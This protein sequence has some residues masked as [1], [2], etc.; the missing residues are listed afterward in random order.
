M[1]WR[2]QR[3]GVELCHL[4]EEAEDVVVAH[5]QRL[6]AGQL[7][8]LRLECRHHLAAVVTQL[9][10]V[11][12]LLAVAG[13]DEAPVTLQMRKLVDKGARKLIGKHALYGSE[14][15]DDAF[16]LLRQA[17]HAR[18]RLQQGRTR[19]RHDQPV[20]HSAEIARSAA[21]E[22][23]PRDGPCYVGRPT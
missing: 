12:E 20:A 8:I 3:L 21:C 4:D 22:R 18:C 16:Q 1:R 10:R 19:A 2:G 9:Q 13:P 14:T 7:D 23:K 6:H 5:L 17:D 15:G 11:V